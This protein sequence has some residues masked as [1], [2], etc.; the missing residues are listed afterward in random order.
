MIKFHIVT[1]AY[2]CQNYIRKCLDMLSIQTYKNWDGVVVD[3]CSTDNTLQIIKSALPK[4][5]VCVAN[6]KNIGSLANQ[7]KALP[8]G[9]QKE[10][11]A[12]K[13]SDEDVIVKV[14]GDDWLY[15]EHVLEKLAVYYNDPEVWMTYGSC[16]RSTTK[17]RGQ[18]AKP[19]PKDYDFR[20]NRWVLS[21]LRSYKYFLWKNIYIDDLK[22]NRTKDFYTTSEDC[23][24]MKPMAEMAGWEHIKYIDEVLYVYN[25]GNPIR[26]GAIHKRETA[27][28]GKEIHDSPR[29]S[30]QKKCEL[31]AGIKER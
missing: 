11:G 9:C 14:D 10:K 5:M 29:Y 6:T 16:I 7:H 3:D 8:M 1:A 17:Q 19:V 28:N 20:K 25:L 18:T 23:A 30:K 27:V 2:N 26:D 4:K 31:F 13:I 21:H 15:D 12:I 22:S 24:I